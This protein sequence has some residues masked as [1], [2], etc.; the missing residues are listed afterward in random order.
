MGMMN[1]PKEIDKWAFISNGKTHFV[2]QN[3]LVQIA[4][5]SGD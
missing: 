1:K 2:P 3:N 5:I 4:E